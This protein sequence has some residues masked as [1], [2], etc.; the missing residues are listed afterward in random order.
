MT[1]EYTCS[2]GKH[3]SRAGRVTETVVA[4]QKDPARFSLGEPSLVF[5]LLWL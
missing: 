5:V 3:R 1:G 4:P 2:R